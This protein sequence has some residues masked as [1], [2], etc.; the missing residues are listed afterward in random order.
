MCG[1]QKI[2]GIFQPF[3][4]LALGHGILQQGHESPWHLG[5]GLLRAAQHGNVQ[6][7]DVGA[8]LHV[9]MRCPR[10][11]I[12][13]EGSGSSRGT[14]QAAATDRFVH[15]EA[16]RHLGICPTTGCQI[17]KLAATQHCIICTSLIII[18]QSPIGS[19]HDHL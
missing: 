10:P 18:T 9:D 12:Y 4:R 15:K 6:V 5:D 19:I 8:T 13:F 14:F 7:G 1:T 16:F 11:R 17:R 2:K 3:Q